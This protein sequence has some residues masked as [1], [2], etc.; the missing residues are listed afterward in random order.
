MVARLQ[1]DRNQKPNRH[2]YYDVGQAVAHL[3]VQAM[4]ERLA[5]HQM[6]GFDVDAARREFSIPA[7]W[8]PVTAFAI[9]HRG[10]PQMLPESIRQSEM[11]PRTRKPLDSFV[12]AGIWGDKFDVIAKS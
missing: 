2:A 12:F 4:A 1:F 9:G 5:V 7:G 10:D 11:A 6:A 8:D 3:T